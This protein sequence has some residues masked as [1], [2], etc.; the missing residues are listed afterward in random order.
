MVL[1]EIG[2][3]HELPLEGCPGVDESLRAYVE[4][5]RVSELPKLVPVMLEWVAANV[6]RRA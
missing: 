1:D 3:R 5:G 2:Q 6:A 4:D